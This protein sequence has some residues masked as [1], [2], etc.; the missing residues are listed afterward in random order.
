ML[1]KN[2]KRHK[3]AS[4]VMTNNHHQNGTVDYHASVK[5][6]LSDSIG[7]DEVTLNRVTQNS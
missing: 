1:C 4:S 3:S 6:L 2:F 5:R 7:K